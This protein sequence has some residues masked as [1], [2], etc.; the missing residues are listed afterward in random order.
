MMPGVTMNPEA[1]RYRQGGCVSYPPGPGWLPSA[2]TISLG[3]G[4]RPPRALQK[5]P[6]GA[7]DRL[8][9]F[10]GLGSVLHCQ[11]TELLVNQLPPRGNCTALGR[12]L[13]PPACKPVTYSVATASIC[14][15][16]RRNFRHKGTRASVPF[17]IP[18]EEP[19]ATQDTKVAFTWWQGA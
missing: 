8:L 13:R 15:W 12:F 16:L 3:A 6:A 7:F 9:L 19:S 4:P 10:D 18:D 1:H 17:A 11:S 14:A 5:Q 2:D